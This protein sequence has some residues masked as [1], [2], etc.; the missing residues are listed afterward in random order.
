MKHPE[1]NLHRAVATY[2]TIALK[3][4]TWWT[5]IDHG[6]H[7]DPK[8]AARQINRLHA[9]GVKFGVPDVLV[10]HEG[11]CHWIE[12]KSDRGRLSEAQKATTP[13]LVAAGCEFIV[14]RNVDQ[15]RDA[16]KA[17]GI[18]TREAERTAA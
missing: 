17:W 9:V 13:A 3:P 11:R 6:L 4:P 7:L 14:A 16:L 8:S 10:V 18:P 15:V 1:Y 12:L 5:S 2:L